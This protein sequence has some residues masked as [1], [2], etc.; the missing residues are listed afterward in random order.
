MPRKIKITRDEND[1]VKFGSLELMP[2]EGDVL[3]GAREG[4]MVYSVED[5]EGSIMFRTLYKNGKGRM[6]HTSYIIDIENSSPV[7]SGSADF[8]PEHSEYAELN[9]IWNDLSESGRL[10][11]A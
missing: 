5:I 7:M 6:M 2:M 8:L 1:P 3:T 9:K 11:N 10:Q 4:E